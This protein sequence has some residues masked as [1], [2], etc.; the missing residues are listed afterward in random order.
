MPIRRA[1]FILD[2]VDADVPVNPPPTP[3][4]VPPPPPDGD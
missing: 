1:S 2:V 4:Y 3:V